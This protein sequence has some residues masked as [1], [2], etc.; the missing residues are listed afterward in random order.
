MEKNRDAVSHDIIK[1]VETTTNKL[2][3]QIFENELSTNDVKIGNNK[4][5]IMTPKN[6][7]RV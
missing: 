3:R 6:S 5:V 7:I 4:K 2:L 1:M